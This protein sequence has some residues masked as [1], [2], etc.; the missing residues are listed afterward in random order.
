MA[1]DNQDAE[2]K[3]TVKVKKAGPCRKKVSIEIPRETVDKVVDEQYE[4]L[5]TEAIMPGFRKGRA[6]RRLLEKRFGKEASE[7][8]KLK[9]LAQAS[10]S[11][12]KDNEI[13]M[14]R[15]PDIDY[16]QI[17][18][19]DE[20]P[21]KFEFEVEVRP[22]FDLPELE[23]IKINRA[24]LEVA[25]EQVEREIEQLRRYS[26]VWAVRSEGAVELDDQVI[27]DV[28]LKVED[29]EEEE[30]LDNTEIY[31]RKNGFVG[32]VP[33]EKLDKV[34]K[35]A[36]AGDVKQ[37]NVEVPK[38]YFK[39]EYRGKK[40]DITITVKDIKW[41]KPAE[42]SEDF[43]KRFN[44]E[45][46]DELKE[47]IRDV[48]QS[49][50]EQQSRAEMTEQIYECMLKNTNFDLPTDIVADQATTILQRQYVSMLQRGMSK[51][52]IEQQMEQL[53][54]GSEQ[55]AKKQLKKFFIMDS[56]A[57][58]FDINVTEEEINGHIAQVA[59]QRGQRPERM[60]E[61]MV[62][63]GS[64]G[65]FEMQIRE[66]KCIEKLLE[67]AKITEVKPEQK[68]KK[69]KKN[70]KSAAKTV[71]TT[72]KSTKKTTKKT[73]KKKTS[74][75]GTEAEAAK[76]KTKKISKKKTS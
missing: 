15:E 41:L 59:I 75:K 69:A 50:L 28:I 38:T 24:K 56:V 18:L 66:N 2:V 22:E 17:N 29:V 9:L 58:K 49:R 10:E 6:P 34:L 71:K 51:E 46:E 5:R 68:N 13:D 35:G 72:E 76:K 47:H 3:N 16:E 61:E 32:S 33:V 31:V 40:V 63:D 30:K 20:G 27:A 52:Q 1:D 11:A 12:I 42:M 73:A 54:A 26:G 65:Q 25:D 60:R 21:L 55:Q 64:L 53:R 44:V 23:G 39:E 19:P 14:L 43:L 7:Q 48:L 36:K 37:T 57:K 45:S 67:S 4:S 70:K 8:I 74:A 62:R